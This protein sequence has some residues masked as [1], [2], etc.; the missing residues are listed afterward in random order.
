MSTPS[1]PK[2]FEPQ[3]D[4]AR[5]LEIAALVAG[6]RALPAVGANHGRVALIV[7]RLADG[8]RETPDSVRLCS[9]EGVPGDDWSRRPPRN[10]EAQ[11]AVMRLG[12]AELIANGQPLTL[13]GDNLIVDLDLSAMNL[14]T[15]TVLRVGAAVVEVTPKPH[16]GC[17]KFRGRFGDA[18]LRFVQAPPTRRLNLRG[19]YWKVV[20]PGEVQVGDAIEV[21]R[22]PSAA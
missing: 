19:I 14:P 5:H 11:L 12:V 22:R 10:P 18:A 17:H 7:R 4:P 6:L 8:S 20:D 1:T 16:N 2:P 15:G 3:G 21:M 13:F 9:E